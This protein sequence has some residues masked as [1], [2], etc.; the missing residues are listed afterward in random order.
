MAPPQEAQAQRFSG[1]LHP[2]GA[3]GYRL[4]T[5]SAS[6]PV[7]TLEPVLASWLEAQQGPCQVA[8]IAV[9]NP[10]GPWLRASRLAD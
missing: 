8:L 5:N 7:I 3:G 10:W 2:D 1:H 6:W 9:A 4:D